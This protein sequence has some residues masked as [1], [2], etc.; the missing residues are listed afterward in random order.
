MCEI[1]RKD[2]CDTRCPNYQEPK[3]NRY[4]SICG[5]GIHEG[6]E[7]IENIDGEYAHFECFYGLRDLLEWLGYEI[8]TMEDFESY[9][10][11]NY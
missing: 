11:R 9:Y 3:A 5:Y 10:E 7:Y 8:K 2:S 4:C 1:C 6:E